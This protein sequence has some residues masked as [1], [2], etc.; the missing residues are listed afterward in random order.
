MVGGL[1]EL[2]DDLYVAAGVNAGPEE[3]FLEEVRAHQARAGEG[4]ESAAGGD[5]LHCQEVD[6]LVAPAGRFHLIL[7]VG[8]FRWVED[9]QVKGSPP[10]SVLPQHLKNVS[11]H[12]LVASVS[13]A[14]NPEHIL[15][16]T[17]SS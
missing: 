7:G 6:V 3:H 14:V 5:D 13:E 16:L 4:E 8:E 15:N 1:G 10:I 11:L 9:D 17:M 2:F 12:V